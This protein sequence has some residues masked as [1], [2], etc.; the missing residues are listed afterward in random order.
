M[1][2]NKKTKKKNKRYYLFERYLDDGERIHYV[3]HR[4]V[5]VLKIAA[6]RAVG[7]GITMPVFLYWMFPRFWFFLAIWGAAGFLRV[8]YHIIDWYFDAWLLTENGVIDIEWNGLFDMS[9]TRVDYHMMEGIAY[10]IKGVLPTMFNYGHITIDKLGAK[11]SVELKD[12]SSPKK[13]ESKVMEFQERFVS[14]RSIRDHQAL[15]QMLSDMISYHVENNLVK[16]PKMR[17]KQDE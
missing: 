3:A 11:T 8:V 16:V 10:T 5:L 1:K 4:H 6:A 15:K 17:R 12:A 13:L 2:K 9:S 14:E 7:F